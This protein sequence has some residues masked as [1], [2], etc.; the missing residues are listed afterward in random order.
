[1]ARKKQSPMEDI[2]DIS[3]KLPWWIGSLLSIISFIVLHSL[4][5]RPAPIMTSIEEIGAVATA[6]IVTTIA[7]FGQIVLPITFAIGAIASAIKTFR[8]KKLYDFVAARPV[9]NSLNDMSWGEF[10]ELVGEHFRRLGFTVSRKGGAGSDGGIDLIL[11]QNNETYLVQCKQWK[12]YKVGVQPV[13]EFYG[14]M[15]SHG[16]TGGYF[17]TSGSFTEEAKD[18]AN[19]VSIQTLDGQSLSDLL[20]KVKTAPVTSFHT[21]QAVQ[22][23]DIPR[24]PKCNS[25][26]VRRVAKKGGNI[27]REFWG[28]TLYPNCTGVSKI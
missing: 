13:R 10:E 28:C 15:A 22:S 17:I 21:N 18:F 25:N 2:I 19:N 3:S 5:S 1:M 9:I 8:Q 20:A 7:K 11:K 6:S 14:V 23:L 26:M 4:A 16:A 27:G 12:T 24:C